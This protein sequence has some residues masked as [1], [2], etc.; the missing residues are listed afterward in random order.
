MNALYVTFMNPVCPTSSA[1]AQNSVN[2]LHGNAQCSSVASDVPYY[3]D[4]MMEIHWLLKRD[5]LPEWNVTWNYFSRARVRA[6]VTAD[7]EEIPTVFESTCIVRGALVHHVPDM[8]GAAEKATE[9][10]LKA[11]Y[12]PHLTFFIFC[13]ADVLKVLVIDGQVVTVKSLVFGTTTTTSLQHLSL[14]E[15]NRG[16]AGALNVYATYLRTKA[17]QWCA[18]KPPAQIFHGIIDA[19]HM[20]AEPDIFW[21]DAIPFF[22]VDAKTKIPTRRF[23]RASGDVPQCLLVQYPQFFSNVTRDDFLDNKNSAYYTVWQTLR[24]CAK[25]ITS[26]GTNAI[27]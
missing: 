2:P 10:W 1:P 25:T 26:S 20:L 13:R 8:Y 4:D 12:Q 5:G 23:G 9:K 19:R 7:D 27:W 16:K 18:D 22:S 6:V 14:L 3:P 11:R 17:L 21:N 24:D 15:Q